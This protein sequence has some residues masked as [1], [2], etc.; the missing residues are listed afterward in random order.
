MQ[1]KETLLRI[2]DAVKPYRPLLAIAMVFMLLVAG[3][4]AA[5][6]YMVKPLLDEIFFNQDRFMLNL[7]PGLLVLLFV[8]KGIC[9]YGYNYLLSKVG[10]SV[11]R[12]LRKRIYQHVQSLPLSFFHKTPTGELISRV[13]SDVTLI[14]GTVSR[15]LVGVIK[16]FFQMIGLIFVIFYMNWLLALISMVFLPLLIYPIVRFGTKHRRLSTDNQ[17]TTALVSNILY[18]TITGNRIV[19]AF[20]REEYEN[21]RFGAML[22][23]L[24]AIT[25]R[26]VKLSSLA[27]PLMEVLGGIGIALVMWYGGTQVLNGTATPG[28]FF[29]FLTAL[30]MIYEPLKGLSKINSM[31][32]QG[33]AASVRVFTLLDVKNDIEE[34]C[35]AHQLPVIHS[36]IGFNGVSF[37]YDAN[38]DVLKNIDLT[39]KAGEVLAI[40]DDPARGGREKT[41]DQVQKR[42]LAGPVGAKQPHDRAAFHFE[43]NLV[44]RFQ[45]AK[46]PCRLVNMQKAHGFVLPNLAR[47]SSKPASRPLGSTKTTAMNISPRKIG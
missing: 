45:S 1:E 3:L 4:S 41:R 47:R 23:K 28:T 30:I 37:S 33:I 15:V 10:Q 9:F 5:Q 32:Q 16:D 8:V 40:E 17:Q 46:I 26:D 34:K 42:C 21:G 22:D 12:D 29:S 11:I 19:K 43:R 25:M 13:I 36:G 18:E 27:H 31:L 6:A 35:G 2:Y 14:Q 24:F 7:V 44:D 38:V 20:C 39:V